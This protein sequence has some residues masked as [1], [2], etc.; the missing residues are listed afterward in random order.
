MKGKIF[1]LALA[2]IALIL[3]ASS[4]HA[5]VVWGFFETSCTPQMPPNPP[6][7]TCTTSNGSTPLVLPPGGLLVAT[8][9]LNDINDTNTYHFEERLGF[10]IV[11]TGATN[12]EFRWDTDPGPPP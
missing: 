5:A 2:S 6:S 8:L 7:A 12:F 9:S 11:E 1:A 10:P 3:E 4:A